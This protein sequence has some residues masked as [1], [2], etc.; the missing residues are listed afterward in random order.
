MSAPVVPTCRFKLLLW[1]SSLM[2]IRA[3][4]TITCY[5]NSAYH[6]KAHVHQNLNEAV[7]LFFQP[8]NSKSRFCQGSV[9]VTVHVIQEQHESSIPDSDIDL[10]MG[11]NMDLCMR[12]NMDLSGRRPCHESLSAAPFQSWLKT[13]T[14]TLLPPTT[15]SF[16]SHLHTIPSKSLP[17]RVPQLFSFRTRQA[18]HHC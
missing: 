1:Y 9:R 11:R 6:L 2:S 8:T 16:D 18:P 10:C 3:I 14:S 4:F 17:L 13:P 12:R 5:G 7:G 15:L